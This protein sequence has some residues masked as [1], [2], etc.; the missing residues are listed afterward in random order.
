M[1][2]SVS[3]TNA[4][5]TTTA[6]ANDAS[7]A[8]P[9]RSPEFRDTLSS[10]RERAL[11]WLIDPQHADGHWCAEL[12]G[13]TILET[14]YFLYLRYMGFGDAVL[15]RQLANYVISQVGEDGGW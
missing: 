15:E 6:A 5:L 9:S 2:R 12:Q 10:C 4:M 8:D 14:E 13:D 1:D 3:D 7:I 11:R